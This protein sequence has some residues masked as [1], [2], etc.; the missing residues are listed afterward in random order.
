MAPFA[1][2]FVIVTATFTFDF[3]I[4][5]ATFTFDFVVVT[6]STM[7]DFTLSLLAAGAWL[8]SSCDL[9]GVKQTAGCLPLLILFGDRAGG[10]PGAS[11]RIYL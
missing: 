2:D 8:R 11:F 5:T 3:V 4:V 9:R 1:F 6:A 7:T 10:R